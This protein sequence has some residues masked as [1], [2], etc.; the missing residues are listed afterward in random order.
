MVIPDGCASEPRFGRRDLDWRIWSSH[1]S[2]APTQINYRYVNLWF[3]THC[4]F[5]LTSVNCVR[6][7]RSC[8]IVSS[9]IADLTGFMTD[10]AILRNGFLASWL[11]PVEL[12]TTTH[13]NQSLR[14]TT[15]TTSSSHDA[16]SHSVHLIHVLVV[17]KKRI[18]LSFNRD[19]GL[20]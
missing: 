16:R 7:F 14:S 3:P 6:S 17:V 5:F 12:S 19:D 9:V 10:K 15:S 20:L 8:I 18:H 13:T 4:S 1:I 2:I 11:D